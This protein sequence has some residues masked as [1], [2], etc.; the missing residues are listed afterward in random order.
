MIGHP[1]K[2][3]V[4]VIRSSSR[5]NVIPQIVEVLV[6][7]ALAILWHTEFQRPALYVAILP[8]AL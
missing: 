8:C 7:D 1:P 2:I 4:L 3:F 5:Q 6:V